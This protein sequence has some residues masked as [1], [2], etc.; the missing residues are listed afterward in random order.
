MRVGS[1][2]YLV[3]TLERARD[4]DPGTPVWNATFGARE[5]RALLG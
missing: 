3:G 1:D 4:F 5:P 2:P